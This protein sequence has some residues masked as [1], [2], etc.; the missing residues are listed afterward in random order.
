M[1][2]CSLFLLLAAAV[3]AAGAVLARHG[4][5]YRQEQQPRNDDGDVGPDTDPN[6]GS[7]HRPLLTDSEHCEQTRLHAEDV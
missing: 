3:Y 6:V 2:I 7:A 5:D 1:S 4:P